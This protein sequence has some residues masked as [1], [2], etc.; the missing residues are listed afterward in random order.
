MRN[1]RM[2]PGEVRTGDTGSDARSRDD[3]PAL[4]PG[5][6]I[7]PK[8][9][10]FAPVC[11]RFW[12]STFFRT[13]TGAWAGRARDVTYPGYGRREAGTGMRPRPAAEL[14]NENNTLRQFRAHPDIW[15]RHRS[16]V[17]APCVPVAGLWVYHDACRALRFPYVSVIGVQSL[18][19]KPTQW[20]RKQTYRTS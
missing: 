3:I 12:G 10:P 18:P 1:R 19:A 6:G 11:S 17:R 7:R 16:P 20:L 13:P 4:L 8:T 14:V 5:P 15:D 9:G 2:Q